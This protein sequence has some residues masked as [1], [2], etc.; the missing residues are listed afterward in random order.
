MFAMPC[1]WEVAKPCIVALRKRTDNFIDCAGRAESLTI[2]VAFATKSA[3]ECWH[4]S[5]CVVLFERF[6]FYGHCLTTHG[7]FSVFVFCFAD[8]ALI[9]GRGF[10][11]DVHLRSSQNAP[12]S[13]IHKYLDCNV[14]LRYNLSIT[15]PVGKFSQL[16]FQLLTHLIYNQSCQ[17]QTSFLIF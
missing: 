15:C 9:D 7:I 6:F 13:I 3:T 12:K 4:R 5:D 14:H 1:F 11:S 17:S 2:H 8:F 16:R 10:A